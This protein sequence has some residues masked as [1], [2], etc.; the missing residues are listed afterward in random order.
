MSTAINDNRLVVLVLAALGALLLVPLLFMGSGT[1]GY[2]MMS[3]TWGGHMWGSSGM[4]GSA[5][6]LAAL[7]RVAFVALLVAGGY[8]LYRSMTR[9]GGDDALE[10]L[11]S[12][13]AR[14][15]LDDEEFERRRERLNNEG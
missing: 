9:D 3:G 1:M 13:Y 10:E 15:D 4:S 6:L 12:A 5:V 14:G 2:G 8:L 11:R 7:L